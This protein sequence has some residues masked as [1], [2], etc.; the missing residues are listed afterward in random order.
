MF[1]DESKR[2]SPWPCKLGVFQPPKVDQRRV[3]LGGGMRRGRGED[4]LIGCKSWKQAPVQYAST[5]PSAAHFTVRNLGIYFKTKIAPFSTIDKPNIKFQAPIEVLR[6]PN[7]SLFKSLSFHSF[8]APIF[9]VVWIKK[10]NTPEYLFAH[11]INPLPGY[12]QMG[13]WI[14]DELRENHLEKT[15]QHQQIRGSYQIH[16]DWPSAANKCIIAFSLRTH[17]NTHNTNIGTNGARC[18][19]MVINNNIKFEW[20]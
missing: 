4:A 5:Q 11:F 9:L 12:G 7:R 13:K 14:P 20:L 6:P 10:M 16:I 8:H 18:E 17:N 1:S 15:H 3:G 2:L 19:C